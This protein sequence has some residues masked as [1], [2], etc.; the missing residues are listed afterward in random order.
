MSRIPFGVCWVWDPFN[1]SVAV[2]LAGVD[3]GFEFQREQQD[4]NNNH[5]SRRTTCLYQ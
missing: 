2:C 3:D 1:L 4:F 5:D